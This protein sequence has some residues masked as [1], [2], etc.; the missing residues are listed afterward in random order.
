MMLGIDSFSVGIIG[1]CL[2]I[3]MVV[4]GVRVYVAAALTGFLGLLELKGWHV[5]AAVSGMIPHS[6]TV[7]YPLSVL[8]LFILIGFLAFLT[9]I[10]LFSILEPG[11]YLHFFMAVGIYKLS[12]STVLV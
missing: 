5:A 11:D 2:L 8:P 10:E 7:T 9:K 6:K 4:L 1:V 3:V 12:R